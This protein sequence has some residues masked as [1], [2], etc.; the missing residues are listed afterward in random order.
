MGEV[1]HMQAPLGMEGYMISW[2]NFISPIAKHVRSMSIG[3]AT[4]RPRQ[5]KKKPCLLAVGVY[6]ENFIN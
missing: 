1:F 4:S 6:I 3:R 5:A 2:I